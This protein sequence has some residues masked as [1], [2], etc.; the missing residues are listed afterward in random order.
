MLKVKSGVYTPYNLEN[1][2]YWWLLKLRRS[3]ALG[4]DVNPDGSV[5]MINPKFKPVLRNVIVKDK[6]TG[7]I[8]NVYE[9]ENDSK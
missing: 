5:V 2:D 9:L 3:R 7:K 4:A 1:V 8:M 6:L